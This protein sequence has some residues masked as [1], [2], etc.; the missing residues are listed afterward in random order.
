[1]GNGTTP[2]RCCKCR[3]PINNQR[4][5]V[6]TTISCERCGTSIRVF[7]F[8]A[9]Y[10]S[11]HQEVAKEVDNEDDASC[12]FHD[13][14]K[15]VDSCGKCGRFICS[16]CDMNIG[17]SHFCPECVASGR[18]KKKGDL[19]KMEAPLHDNI[20]L[21][22]ALLGCVFGLMYFGFILGPIA[23]FLVLRNWNKLDTIVPRMKWRFIIATFVALTAIGIS[24][25]VTYGAYELIKNAVDAIPKDILH[26]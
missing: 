3:Y 26:E 19:L 1:M 18:S 24:G 11:E 15:A 10:H 16:I 6:N 9:L 23:L 20:A 13:T 17:S 25:A 21:L 4:V 14:K 8:P 12:F 5:G 22:I 2:L 7:S